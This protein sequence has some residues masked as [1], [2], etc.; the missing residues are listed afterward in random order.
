MAKHEL[1]IHS[2]HDAHAVC[3]CG[4]WNYTFTGQRTREQIEAEFNL[5]VPGKATQKRSFANAL[6]ESNGRADLLEECFTAVLRGSL[7]LNAPHVSTDVDAVTHIDY[8]AVNLDRAHGGIVLA[9][10]RVA[11]PDNQPPTV[12]VSVQELDKIRSRYRDGNLADPNGRLHYEKL[13]TAT[14]QQL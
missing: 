4:D 3:S 5:H 7:N 9:V 1:K 11:Q 2:L 6:R 14:K 10:R 13:M 8:W 12:S